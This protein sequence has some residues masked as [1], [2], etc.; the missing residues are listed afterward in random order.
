MHADLR[1]VED[2]AFGAALQYFTGSK[3]HNVL[4]RTMAIK[5]GL[6]LN[7]YGLWR[8][9]TRVAARTE[10][11]VYRKLGLPYFEPELRTA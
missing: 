3:D 11:E 2:A 7:E 9:R 5:K 6:K 4:V 10:E 1:V 8:G